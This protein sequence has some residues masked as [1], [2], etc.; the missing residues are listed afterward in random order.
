MGPL[1]AACEPEGGLPAAYRNLAVPEA[2][3]ADAAAQ[4][5]G[6]T[7]FL[8]HCALCHGER[9]DG[10]GVRI[11]FSSPPADFT[12]PQWRERTSPRQAFAI[13]RGGKRGTSMGA[14]PAFSG[15][16]VWDLVAFLRA[17]SQPAPRASAREE[18][19]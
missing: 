16:E 15:D 8:R 7:L 5:R 12:N 10:K 17:V 9:A 2:R 14:W 19:P 6:R 3:L 4:E 1:L 13:V 18:M 11:T